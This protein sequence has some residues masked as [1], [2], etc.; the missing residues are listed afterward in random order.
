MR[1]ALPNPRITPGL[2]LNHVS[3]VAAQTLYSKSA[4]SQLWGVQ[5]L[6]DVLRGWEEPGCALKESICPSRQLPHWGASWHVWQFDM[7]SE[8]AKLPRELYSTE[9]FFT[10]M[11]LL[12]SPSLLKIRETTSALSG[13]IT[14]YLKTT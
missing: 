1:P 5:K 10:C 4:V 6:S 2:W 3:R 8:R 14:V 7:A 9:A 12:C 13:G 11:S